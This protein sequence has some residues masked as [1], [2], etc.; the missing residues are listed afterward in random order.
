MSAAVYLLKGESFLVDEALHKLYVET[1]ADPLSQIALD[2]AAPAAEILHALETPTL[3]GG[4]RLVVV[5]DVQDLKKEQVDALARYLGSP[6][7]FSILVLVASGRTKLDEAVKKAGSV[8][9]LD[10]PKGRRLVGWIRERGRAQQLKLDDSAAWALIDSV[11]TELRDLDGALQ[12]LATALGRQ[13]SVTAPE[14]RRLFPRLADERT[15]ALTDAV[16]DRR[17]SQAMVALRRLLEQEEHPLMLLGALTGQVR[18]MMR[19]RQHATG[20]AQAVGDALGLPSWRAERLAKQARSYREE[21]L[22]DALEV[23]A[24]TDAE[25]KGGDLPAELALERAVVQ[26]V[27]GDPRM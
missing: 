16:G 10:P 4:R 24:R 11:G 19:A 27:S 6:S 23:L 13:N 17:L 7:P 1:A 9:A 12:Q 15:F 25:M 3:L 2:A 14:V 26:I 21:E 8:I 5:R 22:V 20:G 18:R